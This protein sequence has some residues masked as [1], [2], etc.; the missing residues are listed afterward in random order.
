MPR[1]ALG[2]SSIEAIIFDLDGVIVASEQVWDR[3]R[4]RFVETHRGTWRKDSSR[5]MMGLSTRAW[6][7]YLTVE[8]GVDL[9]EEEVAKQ[10]IEE[11]KRQYERNLPFV[12]G[13]VA[14]IRELSASWPMAVASGSPKSL[15]EAVLVGGAIHDE[16][17]VL[18]SSDEVAAGKPAAD[19]YLEAARRLDV[20]AERCVVVEDSLNGIRSAVAAG[21]TVIAIPNSAYAPEDETISLATLVLADIKS[22]TPHL[23]RSLR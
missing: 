19:V 8:L 5:Q 15:I 1:S 21:A 7:R 22:L 14:A 9:P 4:R 10:V 20:S 17:Q 2:P 18:V 6:A 12:D 13:A 11:M 16:F 23:V 3:V